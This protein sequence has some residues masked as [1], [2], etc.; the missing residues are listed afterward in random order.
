MRVVANQWE[1]RRC[2]DGLV[3]A[4]VPSDVH[5]VKEEARRDRL[6]ARLEWSM[7]Y[8]RKIKRVEAREI[9][10]SALERHSNKLGDRSYDLDGHILNTPATSRPFAAKLSIGPRG[11][12]ASGASTRTR[13]THALQPNRQRPDIIAKARGGPCLPRAACWDV[14]DYLEIP[15]DYNDLFAQ[16][17]AKRTPASYLNLRREA[18]WDALCSR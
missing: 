17:V 8:E 1:R 9:G 3:R 7:K 18:L 12:R 16:L 15:E 14:S 4:Q 11:S 10:L 6:A 5:R 2:T 13:T